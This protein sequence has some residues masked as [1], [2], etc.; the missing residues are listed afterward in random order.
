MMNLEPYNPE[1]DW[2]EEENQILYEFDKYGNFTRAA[3]HW[4]YEFVTSATPYPPPTVPEGKYPV[5]DVN[6]GIWYIR[7]EPGLPPPPPPPPTLE[8]VRRP[9]LE[10]ILMHL[11]SEARSAGYGDGITTQGLA[12]LTA[13]SYRGDPDPRFAA[14]GESF[15]NWRS[16]VMTYAFDEIE[17][18]YRGERD[19]PDPYTLLSE[20]PQREIQS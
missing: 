15:F 10:P 13:I 6:M 14:D 8:Q 4:A 3:N 17:K 11:D 5:A 2:P 18:A 20:L 19:L 12:I 1:Y 7:N 16:S 9:F